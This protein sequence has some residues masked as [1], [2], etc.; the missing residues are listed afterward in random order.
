MPARSRIE[1]ARRRV[2]V[3]RYSIGAVAT[4]AFGLIGL[5][6]R[7]AQPAT[8]GSSSPTVQNLTQQTQQDDG[9]GFDGGGFISPSTSSSPSIQSGGS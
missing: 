8:H 1:T 3:A 6:A 4:A 7:D 2:R 5:A 9:F